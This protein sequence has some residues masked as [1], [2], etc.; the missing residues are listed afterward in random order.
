MYTVKPHI[1]KQ[2][3]DRFKLSAKVST[4]VSE[5]YMECIMHHGN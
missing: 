4:N 1:F 5:V 3:R 2:P